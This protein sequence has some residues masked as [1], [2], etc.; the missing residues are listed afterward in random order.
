MGETAWSN[1]PAVLFRQAA[2]YGERGCVAS[3]QASGSYEFI[4]WRELEEMVLAT[5]SYLLELGVKP[6]DRIGIFS[7]NRPEWWVADLATLAVGAIDV[8]IYPTSSKEELELLLSDSGSTICFTD[9]AEHC[10]MCL[11]LTGPGKQLE[12]VVVFDDQEAVHGPA[13]TM[14]D[15]LAAGRRAGRSEE[16]RARAEA[17]RRSDV[18]TIIYTSGTTGNPKGVVLTHG[19]LLA[20]VEQVMS[21]MK[22]YMS[23]HHVLVSFLPLSHSFE[24]TAGF[25]LPMTVGAR[26]AFAED[27]STVV[28]NMKEIRP[29]FLV[30]VPRL[31]E[32][33]RSTIV[34]RVPE[35]SAAKRA[36]FALAMAVARRNTRYVC[37]DRRAPFPLSLLVPLFDRLVYSR[38]KAALGMDRLEFAVSGG[39]PLSVDDA[40]FFL[41][42]GLRILEGFGLTETSPV[43]NVNPPWKIKPGT[44]GPPVSGTEVRVSDEGEYLVRGPQVM[45]GYYGSPSATAEAF[46]PDGFFRTGDMAA[47]DDEGYVRI[48][49]RLKDIIVT[50]AG[51][52]ISPQNI[53]NALKE[54]SL[55]EQAAVIGER[56]RYL[57]ALVVPAFATLEQWAR[58]RGLPHDDR[59]ELLSRPEVEALFEGEVATHT[60]RFARAEQIRKFTLVADEWTTETGELTPSLKVKRS[61]IDERYERAIEA[62]YSESDRRS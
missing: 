37:L 30:S 55:I 29:T 5:A 49:G 1:L 43:T 22:D 51:K 52:N 34:G 47:I 21:D 61:V 27:F 2:H 32:K 4:S 56:R 17:V 24:R 25:Y 19:N 44:V 42:M 46:T 3:K 39:A 7:S 23:D 48:T 54:S 15:V 16:V 35:A 45:Q 60:A 9:T 18:A 10:G 40:E 36:L 53:E 62:M 14:K 50:A 31:Y 57:S 38:L 12:K 26:V 13:P 11:E 8:P 41:G 20:N 6:G 59:A 58:R 28:E 33:I